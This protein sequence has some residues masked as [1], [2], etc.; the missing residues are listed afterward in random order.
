MTLLFGP[1]PQSFM[2]SGRKMRY[3][4]L[5]REFLGKQLRAV[6]QIVEDEAQRG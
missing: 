4:I 6:R 2:V 5:G 3:R 1:H